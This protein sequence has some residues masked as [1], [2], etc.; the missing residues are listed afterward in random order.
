M[1]ASKLHCKCFFKKMFLEVI[2]KSCNESIW[3]QTFQK[4]SSRGKKQLTTSSFCLF[5]DNHKGPEQTTAQ[6]NADNNRTCFTLSKTIHAFTGRVAAPPHS[7][8]GKKKDAA[9]L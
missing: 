9:G 7:H 3:F 1:N 5:K 6:E 2:T 4:L 8:K